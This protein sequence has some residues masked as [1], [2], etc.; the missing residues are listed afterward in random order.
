MVSSYGTV[1]P[2]TLTD[3]EN[4]EKADYH[5]RG[6]AAT[7]SGSSGSPMYTETD[8]QD[9]QIGLITGGSHGLRFT[10]PM[11]EFFFNNEYLDLEDLS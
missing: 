3:Q 11:L 9:T 10:R 8:L 7:T 6:T 5:L 1:I 4:P 2:L